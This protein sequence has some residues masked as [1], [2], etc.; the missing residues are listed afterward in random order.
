ML[1]LIPL[2][3][4]CAQ[5]LAVPPAGEESISEEPG[6]SMPFSGDGRTEQ[7]ACIDT[8]TGRTCHVVAGSVDVPLDHPPRH[9]AATF[10]WDD[11][12]ESTMRAYLLAYDANDDWSLVDS[13]VADGASPLRV[14]WDV[15]ASNETT[16]WVLHMA[17]GLRAQEHHMA[18]GTAWTVDGEITRRG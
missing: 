7:L 6:A 16:R 18:T 2:L 8:P 14:A 1:I 12:V 17:G 4:G 11:A 3:A 15:P 9:V 5:P 10:R 13:A